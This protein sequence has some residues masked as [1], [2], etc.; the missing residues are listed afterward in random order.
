[1]SELRITIHIPDYEELLAE[2]IHHASRRIRQR[3]IEKLNEPK[4]G[5]KYGSHTASAPGEAPASR[6]KALEKSLQIS[7]KTLES[8]LFS[9]VGYAFLLETGTKK[10]SP[11]PMWETTVDELLPELEIDLEKIAKKYVTTV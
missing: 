8:R 10:M 6:T 3:M 7:D 5:K 4:S 2:F 1:M 9:N 11:R